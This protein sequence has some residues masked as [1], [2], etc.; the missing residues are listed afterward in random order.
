MMKD[1]LELLQAKPDKDQRYFKKQFLI[2]I[3][4]ADRAH[5]VI[6]DV[7]TFITIHQPIKMTIYFDTY[8]ILDNQIN[9]ICKGIVTGTITI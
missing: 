4:G 1:L 2:K 8:D 9:F 7:L 5:L 6:S 3:K